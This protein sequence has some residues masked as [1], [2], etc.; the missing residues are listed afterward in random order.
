MIGGGHD[1]DTIINRYTLSHINHFLQ[2]VSKRERYRFKQAIIS[3]R[4]GGAT[5][6]S[7]QS[8][9]RH[10]KQAERQTQATQARERGQRFMTYEEQLKLEAQKHV[11]FNQL[12]QAE[13][14]ALTAERD[15]LWAQI[16][17]HI[18]AKS[19]KLA[20]R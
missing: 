12:S 4:V 8:Y 20:G 1:Y 9:M 15:S 11:K 10:L 2:E 13:Q 18:Q 5:D 6:Q 17:A 3:S 19:R 16:P 7:Y 14:A